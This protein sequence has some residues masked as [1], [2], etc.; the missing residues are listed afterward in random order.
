[1]VDR[2][3]RR[4][5]APTPCAGARYCSGY[6]TTAMLLGLKKMGRETSARRDTLS[7]ST[8]STSLFF[9]IDVQ[10]RRIDFLIAWEY[11]V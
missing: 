6:L 5:R 11:F 7:I 8:Q 3:K 9:A 2:D 1:M 4:I 10:P